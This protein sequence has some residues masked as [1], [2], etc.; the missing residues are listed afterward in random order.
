MYIHIIE[1]NVII[2]AIYLHR[3]PL[4]FHLN[5]VLSKN[6]IDNAQYIIVVIQ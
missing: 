2:Y 1:I 3:D 4:A 6:I 5:I